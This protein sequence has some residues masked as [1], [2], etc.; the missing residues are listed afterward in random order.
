MAITIDWA[1]KVINVPKADTQLVDAGPP[2][3]RQLDIDAFRLDLKGIEDSDDGMAFLHTHNHNPPV[4][5]GG[6]TLARVFEIIN[7][8]T[9]T[10]EDGQY[11]VNLVGANS[12]IADVTNVNQVSIR[13]ANSAGLTF[14]LQAENTAFQDARVWLDT[15]TGNPGTQ[16]PRGTV[17]DPVDNLADAQTIILSRNLPKRLH[18]RGSL[19]VGASESVAEYDIVGPSP[20]L[21]TLTVTTGGNTNNLVVRGLRMTGDLNGSVSATSA[22]SFDNITDFDGSMKH[23][24]LDGTIDLGAG[25]TPPHEFVDCYSEVAGKIHRRDRSQKF[26]Q[27]EYVNRPNV[28]KCD[29]GFLLHWWH[30]RSKRC[31]NHLR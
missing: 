18:L 27:R 30:Y 9:V 16:Y 28:W 2:E 25:G 19:T 23:C 20:Q 12:N 31:R 8:Y 1:T 21:A 22:V 17:G 29:F 3:I 6:V 10:F 13:S 26:H 7:G 14:S 5:V 24:G 4:T 11:A 15:D